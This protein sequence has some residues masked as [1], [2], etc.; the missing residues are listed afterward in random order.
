MPSSV[1]NKESKTKKKHYL[2]QI[3]ALNTLSLTVADSRSVH[4]RVR[5]LLKVRGWAEA[6]PGLTETKDQDLIRLIQHRLILLQSTT[7]RFHYPHIWLQVAT[8]LLTQ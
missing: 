7:P 8:V 3:L 6:N 4:S 5:L 1:F 2:Y